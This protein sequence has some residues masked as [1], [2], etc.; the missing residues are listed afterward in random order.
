MF[1]RSAPPTRPC[2]VYVALN[3]EGTVI[4]VG[5]SCDPERRWQQHEID[6]PWAAEVAEWK[7][8]EWY[9]T[10]REARDRETTLI[11]ALRTRWNID[12]SPVAAEVRARYLQM[13]GY[14]PQAKPKARP[15]VKTLAWPLRFLLWLGKALLITLYVLVKFT[16]AVLW[17]FLRSLLGGRRG[18]RRRR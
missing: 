16:W 8:I 13:F 11:R 3:G 10:E 17:F 9:A 7:A 5:I 6:K 12:E 1:T 4:Y 15:Y 18:R 14:I 2:W